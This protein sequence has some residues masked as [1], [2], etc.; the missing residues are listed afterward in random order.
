MSD[1]LAPDAAQASDGLAAPEAA[2]SADDANSTLALETADPAAETSSDTGAAT[3][4]PPVN[5]QDGTAAAA[6]PK[7]TARDRIAEVIA[8][9]NA[10]RER[11]KAAADAA[12]FWRKKA[13]GEPE[14]AAAP[15]EKPAP[16]LADFEFD[17]DRWAEAHAA[18][19]DERIE[20]RATA[21]AQRM[22]E[23]QSV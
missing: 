18:W 9:R 16:K 19:A 13:L 14:T 4:S 15:Q 17:T 8:E 12:E 11:T 1:Q 20:S 7:P 10:E 5:D 23:Q 22:F 6:K 3:D 2:S 21:A